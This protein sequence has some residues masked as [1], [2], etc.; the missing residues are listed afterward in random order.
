MVDLRHA[1][2]LGKERRKLLLD[3]AMETQDMDNERFLEKM[4]DRMDRCCWSPVVA[5][6]D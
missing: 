6:P 1:K 2:E 5:R 4:K 3:R